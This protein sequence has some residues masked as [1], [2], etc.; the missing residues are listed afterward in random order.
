MLVERLKVLAFAVFPE[1]IILTK[2][3]IGIQHGTL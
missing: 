2:F 1:Y 3:G